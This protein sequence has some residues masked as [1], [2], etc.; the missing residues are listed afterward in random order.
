MRCTPLGNAISV[1]K[2]NLHLQGILFTI[3]YMFWWVLESNLRGL[4]QD[5]DL[6]RERLSQI[7]GAQVSISSVDAIRVIRDTEVS[8]LDG[9]S[10]PRRQP[11]H[12]SELGP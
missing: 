11:A 10:F 8:V 12:L 7:H 3:N 1:I 2:H 9:S 6:S 4:P 5:L